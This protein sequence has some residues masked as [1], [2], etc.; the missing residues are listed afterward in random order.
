MCV[1]WRTI[2]PRISKYRRSTIDFG[3]FVVL[4][5]H[6]IIQV[7]KRNTFWQFLLSYSELL[8]KFNAVSFQDTFLKHCTLTNKAVWTIWRALFR[9]PYRRQGPDPCP[10]WLKVCTTAAIGPDLVYKLAEQS[11][12]Q[13]LSLYIFDIL[14]SYWPEMFVFCILLPIGL[15]VDHRTKPWP[16]GI[17]GIQCRGQLG[18]ILAS[19]DECPGS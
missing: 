3:W 5:E 2:G 10:L 9:S 12:P 11:L 17:N 8:S 13:R 16:S 15:V 19:R 7:K 4:W 18:F 6:Q 1:C 14:F